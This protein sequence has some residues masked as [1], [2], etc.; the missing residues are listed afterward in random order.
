MQHPIP[1]SACG[2]QSPTAK[3]PAHQLH[4]VED[5]LLCRCLAKRH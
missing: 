3:D 1:I 4:H 5:F 2:Q